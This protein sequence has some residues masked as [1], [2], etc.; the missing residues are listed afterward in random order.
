[1][2]L[3]FRSLPPNSKPRNYAPAHLF[4]PS[5]GLQV[6]VSGRLKSVYSIHKKMQRKRVPIDEIYDVR[7]LRVVVDDE[8]G[9]KVTTAVA[10]CYRLLPLVQRIW[11]PIP[12]EC[13]DYIAH[14]KPSGYQSLHTAVMGPGGAPLEVQVRGFRHCS[15]FFCLLTY[16]LRI[17]FFFASLHVQ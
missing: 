17:F 14:P 11:R 10:A 3:H 1:M 5:Q 2:P 6:Y 15:G 8:R 16:V 9:K 12:G 13:D 4:F 7:A